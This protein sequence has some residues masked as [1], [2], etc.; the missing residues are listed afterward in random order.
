MVAPVMLRKQVA[1]E[2]AGKSLNA[3]AEEV[4]RLAAERRP[5]R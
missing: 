4:L 1:A 2:V 3:W 5:R